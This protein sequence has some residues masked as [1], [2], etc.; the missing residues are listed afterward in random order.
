LV[1]T[2]WDPSFSL[3]GRVA[4]VTGAARG[5]G[6]AIAL[7]LADAGA[8]VVLAVRDADGARELEGLV[9]A[10]GRR[11][12]PVVMDA[13]RVPDIERAVA[14]AIAQCGR[15]DI[16]V[17]NVGGGPE[18]AAETV[19]EADFDFTIALNVKSTFF[20][21]KVVA[22]HMIP[23]RYGRMVNLSSQAAVVALPGESVYCLAKAAVSHLT[24]CLAVEWGRHGITVNAVAPTFVDTPGTAAALADPAFKAD[25][26]E[27]I[28]ALHRLGE[29]R[30]VADTVLFLAAPA[31]S[32]ITGQTI[33]ADGGWTAR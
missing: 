5:L 33:L 12:V 6:H 17:N 7:R 31:S 8:D 19:S 27:R 16:L 22:R 28:A 15:I 20:A 29:P 2:G 30:E 18:G 26:L 1:A 23:R 11:A 4:M 32:L 25:V 14:E 10:K 9:R 21:S 13:T 3:E 24:K